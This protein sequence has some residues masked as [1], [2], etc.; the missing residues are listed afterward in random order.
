MFLTGTS[1]APKPGVQRFLVDPERR[2]P[3]VG[4]ALVDF[5]AIYLGE[6]LPSVG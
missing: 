1:A 4:L 5:Q 6:K 2:L 3:C